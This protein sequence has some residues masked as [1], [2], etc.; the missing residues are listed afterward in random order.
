MGTAGLG[1]GTGQSLAAEGI[2]PDHGADHIAV[3][4]GIAH[5]GMVEDIPGEAVD[6]AVHTQGQAETG[7]IDLLQYRRNISAFVT[8][9]VQNRTEY[10]PG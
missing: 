5:P 1:S 8:D 2:Y 7:G 6:A 9:N 4:V 10:F 3:D